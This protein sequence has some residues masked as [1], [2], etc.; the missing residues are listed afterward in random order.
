[1]LFQTPFARLKG[2]AGLNA[3]GTVLVGLTAA[4]VNPVALPVTEGWNLAEPAFTLLDEKDKA[5][6]RKI[7]KPWL[8]K[9]TRPLGTNPG[10]PEKRKINPGPP[11]MQKV[12][13]GVPAVQGR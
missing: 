3:A 4:I 8:E 5:R 7:T 10:P 2:A 13:P 11:N 6:Q 12:N 1:M 9:N